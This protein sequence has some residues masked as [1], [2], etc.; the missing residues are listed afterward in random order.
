MSSICDEKYLCAIIRKP[1]EGKTFVCLENI[2][3]NGGSYHLIITMNT[4]KSN[5]Q[6]FQR[7][8]EKFGDKICVFNSKGTKKDQSPD[9]KHAKDVSGVKKKIR[10][11]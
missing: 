11:I 4:I 1:Q 8:K 6:F 3:T 10:G 7:A 9:F 5:L 2:K